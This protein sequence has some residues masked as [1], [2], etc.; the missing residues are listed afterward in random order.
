MERDVT[1]TIGAT[2]ALNMDA[3]LHGVSFVTRNGERVD[4]TRV[5]APKRGT[6]LNPRTY[7]CTHQQY[8]GC[9]ICDR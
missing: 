7:P 1:Q 4:P 5:S 2:H 6:V 9:A 8:Y 3:A